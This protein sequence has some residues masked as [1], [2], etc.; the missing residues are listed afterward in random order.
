MQVQARIQQEAQQR[1]RAQ[2]ADEL[3]AELS[4]SEAGFAVQS[5][6]GGC[7]AVAACLAQC[8]LFKVLF[9]RL[10]RRHVPTWAKALQGAQLFDILAGS[11]WLFATAAA[12]CPHTLS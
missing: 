1:E 8:G 10:S 2:A 9:C 5:S 7:L 12:L 6:Q 4:T 11:A 3:A